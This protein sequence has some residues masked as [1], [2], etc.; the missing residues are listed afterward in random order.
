MLPVIPTVSGSNLRRH[1]AA[2]AWRASSGRATR[3]TVTSP[4]DAGKLPGR[5][6][7]S[8]V[9]PGVDRVREMLV[10]VGPLTGQRDEQVA[11]DDAARIDGGTADGSGRC[12]LDPAAGQAGDLGAV[13]ALARGA[14]RRRRRGVGHGR[15]CPIAT[16]HRSP[17]VA[18]G[19]RSRVVIASVARRRNSSY[20]STARGRS[21]WAMWSGFASWIVTA[22]TSC[23]WPLPM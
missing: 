12:A 4:S 7:S 2:T 5:L 22:M 15:Q 17:W 23:G 11:R 19:D 1:A 6:T 8:P 14:R 10:T 13:E 16:P 3:I 21:P 18:A 9:G 20:D